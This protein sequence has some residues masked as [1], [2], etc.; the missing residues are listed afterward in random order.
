MSKGNKLRFTEEQYKEMLL[1]TTKGSKIDKIEKEVQIKSK[2]VGQ[3][4]LNNQ[5]LTMTNLEFNSLSSEEKLQ[6]AHQYLNIKPKKSKSKKAINQP[7]NVD[8]IQEF[9]GEK[10]S[11]VKKT[12]GIDVKT[13]VKEI[14]ECKVISNYSE[15]HFSLLF[16]GARLLSVN[17]IFAILQYRKYEIFG[18]K[19]AWQKIIKDEIEKLKDLPY[20]T[21]SVELTLF[22]Q[23]PR[24]VDEDALSVMFKFIIDA[25]KTDKKDNF[26]GIIA[27]DNPK[28]VQSIKLEQE[29]GPNFIGIKITDI[30]KNNKKEIFQPKDILTL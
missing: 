16:D 4:N 20:F 22:R 25:L 30:S 8:L 26:R 18:Y 28:I 3:D 5:V 23:S 7:D 17:Q 12:Q 24:L 29:K 19:K 27:E 9:L 21:S 6:L 10:E 1:K 13:I 15:Q 14:N 2:N 11:K